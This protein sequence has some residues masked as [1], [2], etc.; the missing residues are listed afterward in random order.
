[1]PQGAFYA[2]P[3]ISGTGLSSRAVADL[4]LSEA[5]IAA[6]SG[7]AF[8]AFGEGY[9]RLSY[10]NSIAQIEEALRRM[11]AALAVHASLLKA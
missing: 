9:I 11:T 4:L 7:T 1:M 8:G 3:H 10:A 5:G 6:L 2:F